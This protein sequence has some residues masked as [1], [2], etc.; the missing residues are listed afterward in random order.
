[1]GV[2]AGMPSTSRPFS[3]LPAVKSPASKA[4]EMAAPEA[5]NHDTSLRETDGNS[6]WIFLAGQRPRAEQCRRMLE[7]V[8]VFDTPRASRVRF[9]VS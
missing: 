7:D 2:E 9:M 8:E 6:D 4:T 3:I 5:R 1:M